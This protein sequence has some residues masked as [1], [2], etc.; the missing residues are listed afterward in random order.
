MRWNRVVRSALILA[1]VAMGASAASGGDDGLAP[2][3]L[4]VELQ[5]KSPTPDI[6][7]VRPYRE[8]LVVYAYR[9]RRVR[10][11]TFEDD[12]VRVAHYGLYDARRQRVVD[13]KV[14]QRA[15]LTLRPLAQLP[16][17]ADV[18]ISDTLDID[19]D[20]TL[21][22][23]VGQR[24]ER[25][26]PPSKRYDYRN[27]LSERM[28]A[29]LALRHQLRLV[30]MG[31]SRAEAGIDAK[32]M[33]GPD[34]RV[35]PV[36]YN[37]ALASSGLDTI[38]WVTRDYLVR[39]PRLEWLVV[40]LSPRMLNRHWS[41]GSLGRDGR[42]SRGARYDREHT[43]E[44]WGKGGCRMLTAEQVGAMRGGIRWDARP[45][46]WNGGKSGKAN[47]ARVRKQLSRRER[48]EHDAWRWAQLRGIIHALGRRGVKVMLFT[49][50]IHPVSRETNMVDDDGTSHEAYGDFVKRVKAL[51][52]RHPNLFFHDINRGGRHG[53]KAEGFGDMD[54]LNAE[55][56]AA[57]TRMV[58]QL[59][60]R[61]EK[62][63][64]PRVRAVREVEPGGE[65]K[66][67]HTRGG[68]W[69]RL[70]E[71]TRLY[72]DRDYVY[73]AWPAV[74]KGAHVWQ[75]RN[76]MKKQPEAWEAG[77]T[78]DRPVRVW[79]AV[80]RGNRVLPRWLGTWVYHGVNV[81]SDGRIEMGLFSRTFGKGKV[82]LGELGG[83]VSGVYTVFV[84]PV[85]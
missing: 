74:L 56:A 49:P 33:C 77:F 35:T 71:K 52:Q 23:D 39:M 58:E 57:L 5:A 43:D 32:R 18:C 3:V 59:R 31:D 27:G 16:W 62:S 2:I 7:Q 66:I 26:K 54:H 11:G 38:E 20:A 21:Y 24:L 70:G 75:P 8:A 6:R 48:Y 37:L 53:I 55:G 72:T 10:S 22:M 76:D 45:W 67:S 42:G 13:R 15:R 30:A 82:E 79:V 34:N 46:G 63:P 14:G 73:R 4:E 41:E 51:E 17:L 1:A 65:V 61:D 68:Q 25:S 78:V 81:R 85:R 47:A 69:A 64:R 9:V 83:Q 29:F 36:A 84:Q 12:S 80:P 44:L 40:G 60:M 50:P 28:G 19:D